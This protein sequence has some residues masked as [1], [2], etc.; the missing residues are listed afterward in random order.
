[1]INRRQWWEELRRIALALALIGTV[2]WSLGITWALLGIA[3]ALYCAWHV[4]QLYF[5]NR[6][7]FLK[8]CQKSP[9]PMGGIWRHLAPPLERLLQR[10]RKR[11]KRL[12]QAIARFRQ[13]ADASPDGAIIVREP[14][15]IVWFNPAAVRLLGLQFPQDLNHPLTHLL[16]TPDFIHYWDSGAFEQPLA[17][18]SAITEG[19]QLLLR[20][21]PYG[22]DHHLILVRD[23]TRLHQLEQVRRDFIANVS[24]EL[25]T[26]LTVLI[27][28]LETL[29]DDPR[30]AATWGPPLAQMQ[31]QTRL[32]SRIVEDLLQLS[33]LEG[34]AEAAMEAVDVSLMVADICAN[35]KRL[36]FAERSIALEIDAA[37][38]L[39]GD[40]AI[41][42]SAFSN[43][44]YNAV[45]Y[46]AAAGHIRIIWRATDDGAEFAV[47]D[48]G[49]G[50]AAHHQQR[51]MERF[52][53]VDSAR[54]RNLGGTG[55]GLSIAK[56]AI[57]IHD[58]VLKVDSKLGVGSRFSCH[59]PRKRLRTL[60]APDETR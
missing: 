55:L 33:Q 47:L 38:Q 34:A 17:L 50:I 11:K 56:H 46:T 13:A 16:R 7:L 58:G 15:F 57:A 18:S 54:S 30:A 52:Y 8:E 53:R 23:V 45:Q 21:V 44:V 36:Q 35:A 26:P 1:M 5:L 22:S 60:E 40:Q 29:G 48:N 3:S 49:S 37:L 14:D 51:L 20:I 59:F 31:H 4:R 24:H 28:Y 10:S 42:F 12:R 43:L 27:G 41:L 25:R 9:P 39:L 32:M 6:W 19:V 2:G